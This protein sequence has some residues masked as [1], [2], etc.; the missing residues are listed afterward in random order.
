[1]SAT[2]T[3]LVA[4]YE[5]PRKEREIEGSRYGESIREIEREIKGH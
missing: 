2:D 5:F 3:A 4:F 1:M